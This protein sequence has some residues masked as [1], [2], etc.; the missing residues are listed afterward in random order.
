MSDGSISKKKNPTPEKVI[1][2]NDK[3][4]EE[5]KKYQGK[6]ENYI[7]EVLHNMYS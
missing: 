5:E 1:R 2:N 3:E 4:E 7:I 6:G